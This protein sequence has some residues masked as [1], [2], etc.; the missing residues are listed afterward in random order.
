[1]RRVRA[2]LLVAV[3]ALAACA[4]PQSTGGSLDGA[5]FRV[6]SKEFTESLILGQITVKALEAAG[7]SVEDKT[8]IQGTTNVRTALTSNALDMYWDYTGTGWTALLGHT[9]AEAPRDPTALYRLVAEEDLRRNHVRW[10]DMAPL[11]NTYA[12]ATSRA[13]AQQLNIHTISDYARLANTAPEQAST[14]VASEFLSRDDGWPGVQ[15]AYGFALPAALVRTVDAGVIYTQIPS[16]TQCTFG[17]VGSTDGRIAAQDLLVLDDD[18]Q[19]FVRYNAALTVR[20]D[21]AA[22]YPQLAR[23]F[24]PITAKLTD[25][26]VRAMNRQVDVDGALPEE[27]AEKFL[28]DNGFLR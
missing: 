12:L 6:G 11:N 24:G 21:V 23:I 14:C 7:A 22:R 17:E 16:G 4:S 19:F 3:L 8:G 1:M 15:K 13:R 10:L 25:D 9:P 27:V 28:T 20:E 26:T 5:S 2:V 18:R